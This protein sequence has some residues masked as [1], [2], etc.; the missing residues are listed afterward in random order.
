MAHPQAGTRPRSPPSWTETRPAPGTQPATHCG[1]SPALR[2][3]PG[4]C[5]GGCGFAVR[6]SAPSAQGFSP[7]GNRYRVTVLPDARHGYPRFTFRL[8]RRSCSNSSIA[9]SSAIPYSSRIA[10]RRAALF[11]N[12]AHLAATSSDIAA[13]LTAGPVAPTGGG[14]SGMKV[15]TRRPFCI[16]GWYCPLAGRS[17]NALGT[18]GS[19]LPCCLS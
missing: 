19:R 3:V 5:P 17:R 13:L 11:S 8:S 16:T 1:G 12:A 2:W 7:W 4:G 10:S 14:L 18:H 6:R 15:S 9:S